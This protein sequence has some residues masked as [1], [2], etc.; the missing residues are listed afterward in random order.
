MIL[1]NELRKLDTD[2]V[3]LDEAIALSAF[4]KQ[5]RASYGEH[6]AEVPDWLNDAEKKLVRHIN[7]QLAD[8]R[9][10]RLSKLRAQ[11]ERTLSPAERREKLEAEI[12]QLEGQPRTN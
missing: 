2:I 12:A 8:S 1:L 7:N 3:T 10:E 5:L 11:R 6:N 4:T 9:A